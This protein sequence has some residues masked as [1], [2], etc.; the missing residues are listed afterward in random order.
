M[1]EL[2]RQTIQIIDIQ[3]KK[4]ASRYRPFAPVDI[5]ESIGWEAVILRLPKWNPDLQSVEK[6]TYHTAKF[7]ILNWLNNSNNK[8]GTVDLDPNIFTS[9][10]HNELV[11]EVERKELVR[12]LLDGLREQVNDYVFICEYFGLDGFDELGPRGLQ[13]KH[14][15]SSSSVSMR[16]KRI[17]NYLRSLM[18]E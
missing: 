12:D 14:H 11:G 2:N 10:L 7:H 3:I 17:I 5:L 13:E 8:I 15:I 1:Q 16:K 6:F 4:A 9:T 18:N